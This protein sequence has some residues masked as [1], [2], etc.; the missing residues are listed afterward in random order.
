TTPL[1]A[2]MTCAYHLDRK[3]LA[4]SA[5][6]ELGE[7]EVPS[8]KSIR[9]YD[10][11]PHLAG[12]IYAVA[13]SS[14][15]KRLGCL[16]GGRLTVLKTQPSVTIWDVET[17]NLLS[18]QPIDKPFEETERPWFSQDLLQIVCPNVDS[19]T[20]EVKGFRLWDTATGKPLPPVMT[21]RVQSELNWQRRGVWLTSLSEGFR[22]N[23]LQDQLQQLVRLPD[24]EEQQAR[25][26]R[27][28]LSD[29]WNGS[30]AKIAYTNQQWFKAQFHLERAGVTG[31]DN[32][33][34]IYSLAAVVH[35]LSKRMVEEYR[36]EVARP[37]LERCL[38][39]YERLVKRYPNDPD[40]VR[41]Y[42]NTLMTYADLLDEL[43]FHTEGIKHAKQ[44]LDLFKKAHALQSTPSKDGDVVMAYNTLASI[45][46]GNIDD[47][48][49]KKI[50]SQGV[51]YGE[52]ALKR[53]QGDFAIQ[54]PLA[55][56]YHNRAS[57]CAGSQE[58]DLATSG[59]QKSIDLLKPMVQLQPDPYII[60]DL[61]NSYM[62]LAA[63]HVLKDEPVQA[64][65][66][67]AESLALIRR[68][69]KANPDQAFLKRHYSELLGTVAGL[70]ARMGKLADAD[71]AY[72]EALEIVRELVRQDPKLAMSRFDLA[73]T[74][75]NQAKFLL[76]Y[77][78]RP[79]TAELQYRK[80]EKLL[81]ELVD[82][83]PR[84]RMYRRDLANTHVHLAETLMRQGK[85]LAALSAFQKALKSWEAYAKD[86]PRWREN[87]FQILT[88][89]AM[90][91]LLRNRRDEVLRLASE[92]TKRDNPRERS[93][94]EAAVVLM[95]LAGRTED[96]AE[97]EKILAQAVTYIELSVKDRDESPSILRRDPQLKL[98]HDRDD[99]KKLL[100][101]V[102]PKEK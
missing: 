59:F 67:I 14:D 91:A 33:D 94:Y 73:A 17:G 49:A 66:A 25:A 12:P 35:N 24:K 62:E 80:A 6:Y 22:G 82:S 88:C 98:L 90:V 52:Q 8:G 56:L 11:R 34:V 92:M 96:K 72:E 18:H 41:D 21:A 89:K 100:D 84:I 46:K 99:F 54:Y 68:A 1:L 2:T 58:D 36:H 47:D 29:S 102:T 26:T 3:R 13:Y 39:I 7:I 57:I 83:A 74:L 60:H 85:R 78:D 101:K 31:S 27:L 4:V 16:S 76:L 51:E 69:L 32:P 71:V 45:Y 95:H 86:Y 77:L 20:R 10:A 43:G 64:T 55:A 38:A 75:H 65:K 48:L 9:Q 87:H 28:M 70:Y 37:S 42:A 97:R 23:I 19:V 50:F 15:G 40:Y 79:L 63:R 93:G 44:A 5:G 81:D 30:E 53:H 61:S